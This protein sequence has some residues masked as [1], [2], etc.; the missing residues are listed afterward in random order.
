MAAYY[1]APISNSRMNSRIDAGFAQDRKNDKKWP[2]ILN[3]LGIF[4]NF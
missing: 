3:E 2:I 4:L 1:Y